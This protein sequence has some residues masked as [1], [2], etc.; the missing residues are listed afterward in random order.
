MTGTRIDELLSRMIVED[1][2][3]DLLFTAGKPPLIEEH[4][5][6]SEFAT[7]PAPPVFSSEEIDRLAEHFINGDERLIRDMAECGSCDCS[8]ALKNLARFRVNI[9]K[10]NRRRAIV[11]R[12]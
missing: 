3:S 2:V 7:E 4:G 6:I 5:S 1:G 11:M 10:Q 8:Y 12:K 9:F